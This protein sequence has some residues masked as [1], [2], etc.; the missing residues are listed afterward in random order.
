MASQAEAR[1]LTRP[2]RRLREARIESLKHLILKKI[3][4][5]ATLGHS[6]IRHECLLHDIS[7]FNA[8]ARQLA[9][10][11]HNFKVKISRKKFKLYI[12]WT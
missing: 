12:S 3:K 1:L 2:L 10:P 4:I 11:P 7:V 6:T 9:S 5:A 8:C